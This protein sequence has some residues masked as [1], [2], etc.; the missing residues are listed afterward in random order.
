MR[1]LVIAAILAAISFLLLA[2]TV[3]WIEIVE[4]KWIKVGS[5]LLLIVWGI[6]NGIRL[7][8]ELAEPEQFDD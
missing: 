7:W 6:N 4:S 2:D 1:Q 5:C 8:K 3:G